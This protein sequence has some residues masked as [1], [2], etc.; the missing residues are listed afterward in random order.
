MTIPGSTT[1]CADLFAA[2]ARENPDAIAVR[3]LE[4]ALTYGDVAGLAGAVARVLQ[5][6]GTGPGDVVATL[7]DRSPLSI[8]A[9][10]GSWAIG[11]AY[12]HLE[13]TEPDARIAGALGALGAPLVLTDPGNAHRIRNTAFVTL[14]DREV[15][16]A[17]YDPVPDRTAQDLA[18]AVLTSGST[19]AP[20]MVAIEHGSLLNYVAGLAEH[21]GSMPAT[22]ASGT[23]FAADLG[24]TCVYGALLTGG[25]VDI[26]SRETALDPV[27]LAARMRLHPASAL[28]CTPSQL[29]A[30]AR[31]CDLADVLPRDVLIVG[32]EAFRPQLARAVR[33]AR[34]DLAV[35]NHYGP[36]ETTIGVL[37][38][39]VTET[40]LQ[41]ATVPI[42]VPLPGVW[43]LLLDD[44]G[45]P[46]PDGMP[47][48]LLIGGKALARGYLGDQNLTVSR[49]VSH[50]E[51]RYYATGDLAM[52]NEQGEFEF[53]GRLD[54][55]LKIRGYRVEPAEI[56]NA[57]L[58]QPGIEQVV[59][60]G[61][62]PD[63]SQPVE[64]TAYI[65]G[66]AD[67]DAIIPRLREILP[68][69]HI[70][71]QVREVSCIPVTANGKADLSALRAL[72]A[73]ASHQHEPL[74][75]RTAAPPRSETERLIADVWLEVLNCRD[76]GI[77]TKFL[78]LGGDSLKSLAVFG[79]LRKRFPQLTIADL[80]AHPTVAGLAAAIAAEPSDT[81]ASA[82]A[83][84]VQL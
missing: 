71:A 74:S 13:P 65:V 14:D 76:I 81:S 4:T 19:G 54:R 62:R 35:Y 77:H 46:V 83:K 66:N 63:A 3:H 41:R 36:S 8:A 6:S 42:G 7:L 34:P 68:A 75:L 55:Q 59:V 15:V 49:F 29:E 24:N 5:D 33:T 11:A 20:K 22:F 79:R 37:M 47:G 16:K 57:M 82:P 21:I 23:T 40:D 43:V 39:K 84:I 10:L 78:D 28:K 58:A 48:Q 51:R 38:H 64:L 73:T 12:A 44:L 25:T 45:L 1:T 72:A 80:F 52:R 67:Q 31:E 60:I 61:E 17:P 53:L 69:S 32:G 30:L 27:S 2:A 56:E 9:A 18:Y 50:G 70:P 26:L